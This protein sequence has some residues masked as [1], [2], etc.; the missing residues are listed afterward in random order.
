[1]SPRHSSQSAYTL[2]ELSLVLAVLSLLVAGIMSIVTQ[3][4]RRA[5]MAEVKRKMDV[6]EAEL[7]D[8]RRLNGRLPCPADSSLPITSQY[9]GIEGVPS[10]WCISGLGVANYVVSGMGVTDPTALFA[11][12]SETV[13]GDIPIKTLGL[14]DD[15]MFDPWGGRF[16]YVVDYRMTAAGAFNTYTVTNASVSVGSITVNDANGNAKISASGGVGGAI[17]VLLSY[18]PDGHGAYQLNGGKFVRKNVGNN[19]PNT[20]TNCHCTNG[21]SSSMSY[22]FTTF[23]QAPATST[24]PTDPSNFD[25]IV[26]F[27]TR[28]SFLNSADITVSR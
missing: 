6:I 20:L 27:Y 19:N 21:A 17:A 18:G 26:R 12:L 13:G 15:Y 23:V 2:L 5:A 3:S 8:F 4:T 10:G 25:D 1:M 28:Q 16:F 11:D 22:P 14:S 9:F 24:S 7:L